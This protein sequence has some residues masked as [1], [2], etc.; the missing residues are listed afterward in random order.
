MMHKHRVFVAGGTGYIGKRLIPALHAEGHEVVA[1]VRERS[2]G[3]IP[4]TCTPVV[5]DAL[6]GN[7]YRRF[8]DGCDTFV[9]L[10]GVAH[11]SPK[12]AAEFR[13]IDLRAGLQAVRVAREAGTRHFVYVSVAQPAPMMNETMTAL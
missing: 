12:K 4:W 8:V 3:K 1:L 6:D 10:V 13:Q 5:G 7:S 2:R 9:Q 11:P